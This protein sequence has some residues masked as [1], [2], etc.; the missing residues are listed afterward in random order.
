MFNYWLP[1]R[2]SAMKDQIMGPK[3]TYWYFVVQVPKCICYLKKEANM[4]GQSPPKD[5]VA[6][7]KWAPLMTVKY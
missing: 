6:P 1:I 7:T 2:A 5:H 3:T 4:G